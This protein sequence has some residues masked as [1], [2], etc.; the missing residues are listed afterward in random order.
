MGIWMSK[1]T[2][3]DTYVRPEGELENFRQYLKN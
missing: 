3:V 1:G 2:S